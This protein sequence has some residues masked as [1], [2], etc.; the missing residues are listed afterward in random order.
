MPPYINKLQRLLTPKA[1]DKALRTS[2]LI[3]RSIHSN[4]V[5]SQPSRPSS[6]SGPSHLPS[7]ISRHGRVTS[8][9]AWKSARAQHD[10]I[11]FSHNLPRFENRAFIALGSNLGDR[12]ALIQQACDAMEATGVVKILRT[13][14][15][16][17]TKAMYVVDQDDFVNGACEVSHCG[18]DCRIILMRID[19]NV[20]A[21][22]GASRF[23]PIY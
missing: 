2:L 10:G 22:V 21:T 20:T 23:P 3:R 6:S 15:L 13:S 7:A 11:R 17:Q 4:A 14:T 8:S 16:Y 5:H 19:R 9:N 18:G 1:A 12:V